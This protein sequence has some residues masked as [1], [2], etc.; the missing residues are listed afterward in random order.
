[1]NRHELAESMQR[2][3]RRQTKWLLLAL[4]VFAASMWGMVVFGSRLGWLAAGD[5]YAVLIA[6]GLAVAVTGLLAVAVGGIRRIPK[7]PHCGIR[8]ISWF[9]AIAVA[10]GNCGR[11]GRSI[12]SDPS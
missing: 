8:L 6:M 10:T 9:L 1:M 2:H 3:S 7:C 12:E 11:C 5:R 4:L